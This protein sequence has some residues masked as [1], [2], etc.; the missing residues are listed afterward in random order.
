[1]NQFFN[2]LFQQLSVFRVFRTKWK[3]SYIHLLYR[4][5]ELRHSH[6]IWLSVT[7]KENI[8][9]YYLLLQGIGIIV[10]IVDGITVAVH[11]VDSIL[12]RHI[13]ALLPAVNAVFGIKEISHLHALQQVVLGELQHYVW[14]LWYS[15][16]D[17][18]F[19]SYAV[20]LRLCV[21]RIIY[22][23]SQFHTILAKQ[24]A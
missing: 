11:L 2:E 6:I 9:A 4:L 13:H 8:S 17:H 5:V 3:R 15:G 18:I 22:K 14:L 23:L 16:H 10:T 19:Q 20:V 1:M 21:L 12:W 24:D 7:R